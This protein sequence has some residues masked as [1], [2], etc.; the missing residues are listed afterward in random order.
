M[1]DQ[2]TPPPRLSPSAAPPPKSR[3]AVGRI[4][5]IVIV[6]ALVAAV[7]V[8]L[9]VSGGDD[10]KDVADGPT[11]TAEV[12][13]GD[14]DAVTLPPAVSW[15][16][17]EADGTAGDIDWGA[18]CDTDIGKLALPLFPQQDCFK[19][20]SG[21]NGGETSPGVT[22]DT[23]KVVVYLAQE[24]DPILNF[25]YA[26]IDND[27]TT[28]Q[29]WETFQKYNEMLSHYYE[30]YGRKVELIRFDATGNIS[31][32]VA[33][34]ADAETIA[35][36]IRPFMV[37]GGPLL[38][39]AFADTLSSNQVMCVGCTPSQPNEWYE[40][41]SPYVWDITKNAEQNQQMVAEYIGKR[42]AGDDAVHAGGAQKD[43]PRV[44]GYVHISASQ[45]DQ[46]LED[47]FTTRLKDDYGVEF[48]KIE[49]YESP[50]DLSGTGRDLITR[51]KE[52]GVTTVVFSG[53]PLAPQTLTKIATDQDFHPEW[54]IT[55]TV[56]VDTT[57]FS[58]SYDQEQWSHA[59]GPSNLA[60]RVDS[61]AAGSLYLYD[62]YYGG[63]P[64]A[65]Q[66]AP[67]ILPPLQFV[68]APLQ[69][70]GTELT[71][72]NF[73]EVQFGGRI[74]PSTPI[75][76][77]L[78]YGNRGIW[79]ATDYSAIDDQTEVWWDPDATGPDELGRDGKGMFRYVDGGR[80]YLP[81]EWPKGTP[82]VFVDD[83]SVTLYDE[84]PEAAKIKTDYQPIS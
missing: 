62:W 22:A 72:E 27:D 2:P 16:A 39:E 36:D 55:G 28:D 15:T 59:F 69:G 53:D 12:R 20:F 11:T 84:A 33:A 3:S 14:E 43:K 31:D 23:I 38:T 21:D 42:L 71:P 68:Y 61:S 24:N 10:D 5:P 47:K 25:V 37:I 26:Q 60:A 1:T 77:H 75:T 79:P 34:V 54:I 18:R 19:P 7:V 13:S 35:N 51:L 17:A 48:A 6:V 30:T 41:R 66:S 56:L 63:P 76:Y 81:G 44:F 74:N 64:P 82:K 58:R 67:V 9:V 50:I 8:A 4:V 32:E 65:D 78:S 83:G 49:T 80:R 57:A 29:T 70:V 73:K 40:Q 46:E 52:A 45:Q